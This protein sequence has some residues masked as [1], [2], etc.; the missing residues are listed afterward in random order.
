[1]SKKF[2]LNK[3]YANYVRENEDSGWVMDLIEMEMLA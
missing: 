1:M 3:E 2:D